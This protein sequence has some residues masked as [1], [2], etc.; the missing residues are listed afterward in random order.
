MVSPTA[1]QTETA[2]GNRPFIHP[3]FFLLVSNTEI[4]L[5]KLSAFLSSTTKASLRSLAAAAVAVL[6]V[7]A[8]AQDAA[9]T[10]LPAQL[11]PADAVAAVYV[12]PSVNLKLPEYEMM[13]LEVLQTAMLEHVGID[14][15][16]ING[17][18]AVFG[19][20]GPM[21]P[22][23]GAIIEFN[24][25]TA[26]ESLKPE[27]LNEFEPGEIAG[28]KVYTMPAFPPISVHQLD[29]KTWVAGVGDYV[30]NIVNAQQEPPGKLA[31]LATKVTSFDGVTV[32]ASVDLIRPMATPMLQQMQPMIP[33]PLQDATQVAEW[34][35]SIYIKAK[36][37][38]L[39]SKVAISFIAKDE[40]SAQSLEKLINDAMAFGTQMALAAANEGVDPE[41]QIAVAFV[42]YFERI[43]NVISDG[44][45]PKTNGSVVRVN[46]DGI[47]ATPLLMAG[48]M[49]P[50]V[51]RAQ[52]AAGRAQAANNLKQVAIAMHNY[53][54]TYRKMPSPAITDDDDEPLLSWRVAILPFLGEQ[55]LYE[56]FK[57]DEPW[58]SPHNIRL[59]ERMP[60]VYQAPSD[61]LAPG[62]TVVQLPIG[63][64]AMFSEG[65]ETRFRDILDGTSNTI[66]AI[67]VAPENAVPWTKPADWEVNPEDPM[68]GLGAI[69]Q[70]GFQAVTGDGAVHFFSEFVDADEFAK[71]LTRDGREVVNWDTLRADI[72]RHNGPMIGFGEETIETELEVD[73]IEVLQEDEE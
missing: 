46:I 22:I 39:D 65:K 55:A 51:T 35:D 25:D 60:S 34:L 21:G 20:P 70:E 73:I 3:H 53:H 52:V 1:N 27:I 14:P 12:S 31:E 13:P 11:I 8:T 41:D 40:A 69:H 16:H 68:D 71:L 5:V 18:T 15:Y 23:G 61:T 50:A 37:G 66:M 47:T 26:I 42:K 58:N 6:P 10:K 38:F 45:R 28:L 56:Q 32:I 7:A 36:P 63:D 57:R 29:S 54:D 33:P 72:H 62:E 19:M 17:V 44:M 2:G 43:S 64:K 67:E 49:M 59:I 30:K 4:P 24:E 9:P 48:F